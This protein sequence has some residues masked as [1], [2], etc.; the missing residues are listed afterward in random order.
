VKNI[1]GLMKGHPYYTQLAFQQVVL[2]NALEGTPPSEI[3]LLHRLLL[4][5]KDYLEKVW[6]DYIADPLFHQWII[7]GI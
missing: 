7:Q 5:E 3:E 6:E 2:V 4:V 1:V